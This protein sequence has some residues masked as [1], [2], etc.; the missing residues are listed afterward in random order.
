MS[1][2]F[3]KFTDI[4]FIVRKDYS[5]EVFLEFMGVFSKAGRF[6]SRIRIIFHV[7]RCL[8]SSLY[9]CLYLHALNLST[10]MHWLLRPVYHV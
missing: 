4:S 10:A 6:D 8:K 7:V 2:I 5:S 3:N 1:N 9:I